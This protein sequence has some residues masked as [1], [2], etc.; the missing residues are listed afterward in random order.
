MLAGC[1]AAQLLLL[2]FRGIDIALADI[3]VIAFADKNV[4]VD[5]LWLHPGLFGF[6]KLLWIDFRDFHRAAMVPAQ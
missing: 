1:D 6:G 5:Y 2:E 4:A 3:S